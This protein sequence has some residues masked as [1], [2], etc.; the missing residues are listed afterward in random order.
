VNYFVVIP[1]AQAIIHSRGVYRQ[2]P[3]FERG[4]R[5]YAKQGSGFVRLFQGGGTSC[6]AVKWAEIDPGE[7]SY[8]EQSGYVTYLPPAGQ[9]E[10]TARVAVAAE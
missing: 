9:I 7:G 6:P 1:E 3:L 5:L 4:G 2:V 10:G 8:A